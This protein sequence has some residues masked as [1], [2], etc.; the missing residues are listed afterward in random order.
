MGSGCYGLD[1]LLY[2]LGIVVLTAYLPLPVAQ[3]QRQALGRR[4]CSPVPS[5]S[6]E[7]EPES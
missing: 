5:P 2:L 7:L 4:S 1:D 6:P 3:V